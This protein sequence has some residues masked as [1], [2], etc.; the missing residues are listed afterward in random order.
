METKTK[1]LRIYANLPLSHRSE[2]IV[3]LSNEPLTWNSAWIEIE[4]DTLKGKKI[5]E[6]LVKMKIIE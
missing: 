6:K 1:F 5:L 3:V 2:I 4:N